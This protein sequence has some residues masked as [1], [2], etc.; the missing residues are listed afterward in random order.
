MEASWS[1]SFLKMS[2]F[3]MILILTSLC[4]GLSAKRSEYS[5][6]AIYRSWPQISQVPDS[7]RRHR[8]ILKFIAILSSSTELTEHISHHDTLNYDTTVVQQQHERMRRSDV[9]QNQSSPE[10]TV[11]SIRQVSCMSIARC[12]A[13]N[14]YHIFQP[15]I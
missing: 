5:I 7:F 1:H 3:A 11:Y 10:D 9:A 8:Y 13:H 2:S 14:P 6:E 4:A 12:K 15:E